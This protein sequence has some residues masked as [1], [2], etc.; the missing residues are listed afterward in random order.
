MRAVLMGI[1]GFLVGS[2]GTV[3]V[4][5]FSYLGFTV[6][7]DFHDFEGATAMGLASIAPLAGLVGGLAGAVLFV[8][9]SRRRRSA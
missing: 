1:F 9:L 4:I 2:L 5:F 6:A 7:T 8:L 3:L